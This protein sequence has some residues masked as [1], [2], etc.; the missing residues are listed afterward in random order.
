MEAQHDEHQAPLFTDELAEELTLSA[1]TLVNMTCFEKTALWMRLEDLVDVVDDVVVAVDWRLLSR[2][3]R[4]LF[5]LRLKRA[6]K[7]LKE[8]AP[9]QALFPRLP[10]GHRV[11]QAP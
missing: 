9:A 11:E 6:K 8:I 3:T 5:R 4:K 7:V 2:P 10:E 1:M